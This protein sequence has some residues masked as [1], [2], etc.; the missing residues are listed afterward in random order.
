MQSYVQ[1]H[2]YMRENSNYMRENSE[3]IIFFHLKL[4]KYILIKLFLN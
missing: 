2:E 1:N 4:K 3:H